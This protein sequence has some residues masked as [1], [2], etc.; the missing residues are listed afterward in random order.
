[1]YDKSGPQEREAYLKDF[2][3]NKEKPC[4]KIS[5]F[6]PEVELNDLRAQTVRDTGD[7]SHTF[8]I[9]Q[10]LPNIIEMC[11]AVP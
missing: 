1:M 6:A 5:L 2:M 4:I 11:V 7:E 8:I 3:A 10:A 9:T